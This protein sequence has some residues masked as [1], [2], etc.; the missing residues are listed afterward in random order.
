MSINISFIFDVTNWKVKE[1]LTSLRA[2]S[3]KQQA[4]LERKLER[5]MAGRV[6]G[7]GRPLPT[8]LEEHCHAVPRL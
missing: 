8:T 6:A 5:L 1:E 3:A 7:S 4:K 2:S